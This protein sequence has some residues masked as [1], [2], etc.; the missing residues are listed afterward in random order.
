[1][2]VCVC[3]C[4]VQKERDRPG[5]GYLVA[6]EQL[7]PGQRERREEVRARQRVAPDIPF[8]VWGL[9]LGAK[10]GILVFRV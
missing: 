6:T 9:G 4:V 5:V 3:V 10:V 1:M 2:C 7:D 8:E